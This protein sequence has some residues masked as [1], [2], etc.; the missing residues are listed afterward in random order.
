M[1]LDSSGKPEGKESGLST[2]GRARVE[3]TVPRPTT[4]IP[5]AQGAS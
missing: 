1:D 5:V 4:R 3:I 2:E